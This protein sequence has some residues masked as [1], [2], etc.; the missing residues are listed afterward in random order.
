MASTAKPANKEA[1]DDDAGGAATLFSGSKIYVE[2]DDFLRKWGGP[3]FIAPL[4]PAIFAIFIIIT[5]QLI[6]N[7]WTGS[8][9]YPLNSFISAAIV[10]CY[11]LLLVF[12]WTYLGDTIKVRLPFPFRRNIIPL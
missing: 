9:G 4:V 10:L 11:M 7:T 1:E 8:C 5:G 3:M 2:G 6:L 12:S